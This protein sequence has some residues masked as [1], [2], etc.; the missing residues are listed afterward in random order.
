MID[1]GIM[2]GRLSPRPKDRIQA[3]PWDTW[4]DEFLSARECGFLTIEWLFEADNFTANPLW[5]HEIESIKK[6]IETTGVEVN[7][8]CADY[9]MPNRLFGLAASDINR[10]VEV[11]IH[12]IRKSALIGVDVILLPVLEVSE[13]KS[14]SDKVE[15]IENLQKP[16]DVAKAMNISLGLE[17]E[18]PAL[19]YR[20]LIERAGHPNLK[21]YY[22]TGN[23]AS[24][25]YDIEKDL[26]ILAPLLCGIHIK[27]RE[28]NGSSVMLGDGN[29][30]FTG[31]FRRLKELDYK[32]SLVLQSWFGDNQFDDARANLTFVNEHLQPEFAGQHE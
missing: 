15:L 9:F 24:K 22:D 11:L 26:E 20:D 14:E 16:L 27:D 1:I 4:K 21:V 6:L 5:T 32:T 29:A 17:T 31:F 8:V 23:A 28:P 3:F 13:V 2:Q 30:N 18:L 12:L 19:E 10:N 7:S 25:G